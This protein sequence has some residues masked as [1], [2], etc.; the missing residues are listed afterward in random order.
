MEGI[1]VGIASAV[2]AIVVG[3]IS[4]FGAK[5]AANKQKETKEVEAR[6]PEW[7]AFLTEV[8]AENQKTKDELN[9][10]IDRLN[11]KVKDLEDGLK[12]ISGKYQVSL[13]YILQW[14]RKHPRDP[15][16]DALPPEIREDLPA[17]WPRDEPNA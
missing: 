16:I 17:Y 11:I 9:G 6:G 13:S 12:R 8:R 4:F 5:N 10:K 7:Q 14:R 15:L 3:L 1:I 2:S